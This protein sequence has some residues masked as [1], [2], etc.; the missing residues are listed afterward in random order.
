MHKTLCRIL[1][2]LVL[3]VV[4]TGQ[5]QAT[6]D[7]V[8]LGDGYRQ[9]TFYVYSPHLVGNALGDPAH[10][11]VRAT[12]PPGCGFRLEKNVQECPTITELSGFGM[13][14]N[15]VSTD[16]VAI[17]RGPTLPPA[18]A[19][20]A[21]FRFPRTA[22][23]KAVHAQTG[24]K[25]IHIEIN[26]MT[27]YGGNLYGCSNASGDNISHTKL[28]MNVTDLLFKTVP[29][30]KG[31]ALMGFS[32]GGKGTFRFAM[33]FPDKVSVIAPLSPANNEY[34]F[35]SATAPGLVGIRR[36]LVVTEPLTDMPVNRAMT[37][38][39]AA[40]F[41][42]T[43]VSGPFNNGHFFA[44]ALVA[45][46][47]TSPGVFVNDPAQHFRVPFLPNDD[48]TAPLDQ[49]VW[50][51]WVATG[52]VP[53]LNNG[54]A[55]NLK[56]GRI[57]VFLGR[58]DGLRVPFHREITDIEIPLVGALNANG[59]PFTSFIA[60]QSDHYTSLAPHAYSPDGTYKKALEFVLANLN[61]PDLD[62]SMDET[63]PYDATLANEHATCVAEFQQFRSQ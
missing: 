21:N 37:A 50:D 27:R 61:N 51:K 4:A 13:F 2:A 38:E 31:R 36:L 6:Y 60:P 34:N 12:I 45:I 44:N 57:K 14:W 23:I 32:M 53:Q 58:G 8:D 54:G 41:H 46:G 20:F 24:K 59:V 55:N 49:A 15:D 26:G 16:G 22:I 48:P 35:P 7:V 33:Q 1:M 40:V 3:L 28:V 62:Y 10:R 47:Q 25:A 11:I 56:R 63:Y 30:R 5:A 29:G 43:V 17:Q 39:E 19:E 9:L 42:G 18:F 52:T